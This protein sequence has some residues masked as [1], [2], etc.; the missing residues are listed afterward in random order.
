[1][2]FIVSLFTLLI[3]LNYSLLSNQNSEEKNPKIINK[4]NRI[5][6]VIEDISDYTNVVTFLKKYYKKNYSNFQQMILFKELIPLQKIFGKECFNGSASFI[7]SD[8][9]L[10]N[11]SW[12]YVVDYSKELDKGVDYCI[13]DSNTGKLAIFNIDNLHLHLNNF[14]KFFPDPW[15]WVFI[16]PDSDMAEDLDLEKCK[17]TV[18]KFSPFEYS[19]DKVFNN[20]DDNIRKSKLWAVVICGN[21]ENP[22]YYSSHF[23]AQ[24]MYNLLNAYNIPP[25][26]IIYFNQ[27][28]SH[29]KT[30]FS[31]DDKLVC[32]LKK[33]MNDKFNYNKDNTKDKL[34]IYISTHG[35]LNGLT[36]H[37]SSNDEC[38]L[39]PSNFAK[40]LKDIN[41]KNIFVIINACKCNKFI[42]LTKESLSSCSKN[43]IFI[44]T[45]DSNN[46]SYGDCDTGFDEN[47][48]DNGDEFLSG[49]LEAFLNDKKADQ[50][51]DGKISLK[52]AYQYAITKCINCEE[53]YYQNMCYIFYTINWIAPKLIDQNDSSKNA[54]L[55]WDSFPD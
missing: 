15:S 11:K 2:N 9:E 16:K 51:N 22:G 40:W 26:R 18:S 36:L 44:S 14:A 41:T 34:L 30:T 47:P 46:N 20:T 31:L 24:N 1:M 53:N 49:F 3:L 33:E 43:I 27:N 37:N 6:G 52:E 48:Q 38:K 12:F 45:S 55:F 32:N 28:E 39:T 4:I 5:N 10:L 19:K 29:P 7:Y 17:S 23:D 8:Y 42:K 25:Q 50:N 13:L 54:F 21:I 35:G